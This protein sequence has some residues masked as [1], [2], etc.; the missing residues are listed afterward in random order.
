[1]SANGVYKEH[2]SVNDLFWRELGV[3][4]DAI[5]EIDNEQKSKQLRQFLEAMSLDELKEFADATGTVLTNS[6]DKEA[7]TN[8]LVNL[9]EQKLVLSLL[10]RDFQN[11]K[12][13]TIPNFYQSNSE[14]QSY[15]SPLA[16]LHHLFEQ[17]PSQLVS[18]LTYH[19]WTVRGTGNIF[20]LDK[21]L[22]SS[23]ARKVLIEKGFEDTLCN[24]LYKGSKETNKY[25]IH[26]YCA[27]G[28]S[29]FIG[30]LYKQVN[31][32]SIAD[33]KQAIRHQ[34]VNTLMF[35]MDSDDGKVEIKTK[36]QFESQAIKKYIENTFEGVL[37]TY[38]TD[39]FNG[40]DKSVFI[41]TVLNGKT[42]IGKAVSDFLVEKIVFRGSPIVNSPEL[43][44]Q[45]KNMDVWPSVMDASDK[46]CVNVESIKDLASISFKSF[47][48]SRT[49]RSIVQDNGNV[50]FTM[51]D[52][53]IEKDTLEGIK[54]KFLEKFGIPMFQEIANSKFSDGQADL[55]DYVMGQRENHKHN[56][57]DTK[58]VYDSLI[59]HAY[60][61]NNTETYVECTSSG[62]PHEAKFD[63]QSVQTDECPLC[64]SPL[65]KVTSTST[66][67]DAPKIKREV[68]RRLRVWCS[69]G[70]WIMHDDSSL[71][72]GETTLKLIR[73][74]RT[75]DQKLLQILVTEQTID[76]R[77][78][79]K[80]HKM[81]TPLIIVSV[82]QQEKF[83]AK[84][85]NECIQAISFGKLYV[86]KDNELKS[87]FDYIFMNLDLR[88][89]NYLASAANKA[90]ES[91]CTIEGEPAKIDKK[92][93]T[94]GDLEDDGFALLKDMFPNSVKWGKQQSGKQ[95]PEG[96]FSLSY[97]RDDKE[98]YAFSFDFKLAYKNEGYPLEISE[99]RK[100]V[101]Y[102][103]DLNDSDLIRNYA[104]Q[105]QLSGH[106]FISN[107]FNQAQVETTIKHFEDQL[108]EP[109]RTKPLFITTEVL[110]YLHSKYREHYLEVEL[111]KNN[112]LH[113]LFQAFTNKNQLFTKAHVNAIFDKLLTK[114]YREVDVMDMSLLTHEV[115]QRDAI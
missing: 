93:Y 22:D 102:V 99:N 56:H 30:L 39:V 3:R 69:D 105:K 109:I 55:I 64:D 100:A 33:Y 75:T 41:E 83:I 34:E 111:A 54:T 63:D 48:V 86:Q 49:I 74:E 15:K 35:E 67:I 13:R 4:F 5:N 32:T 28:E 2:S 58:E 89:K 68:K 52:S 112:Y 9:S 36:V 72:H 1:M 40:Y 76:G 11:R 26:S 79:T 45:T 50:I 53:L 77:L 101:Q 24:L 71:T 114:Q 31:D 103:S 81:M 43:T 104:K 16:Q 92:K 25:R 14:L 70:N 27:I 94:P 115:I 19:Y 8:E 65:R 88:A 61:K 38:S 20:A 29:R 10:L 18:L 106:I 37:T 84:Y 91:I 57:E 59:K 80:L 51:D 95:I 21:K 107:C 97:V 23:K 47:G 87:F 110:T 85:S 42:A 96:V 62:C 73:L 60:L 44:L 12:K 17:T 66:I 6:E 82:G 108:N 90:Y 113:W 78:L 7:T 98:R 46:G